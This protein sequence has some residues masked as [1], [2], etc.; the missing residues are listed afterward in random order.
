M[1]EH[2]IMKTFNISPSCKKSA[3]NTPVLH[4]TTALTKNRS[5]PNYLPLHFFST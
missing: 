2:A 5:F 1:D 3:V 4:L